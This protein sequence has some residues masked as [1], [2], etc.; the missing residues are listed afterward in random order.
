MSSRKRSITIGGH[1]TSYTLEDAFFAEL[2]RLA[3]GAGLTVTALVA[4]I[5]SAR[6]PGTNLSSAIRLRILAELTRRM[7]RENK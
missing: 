6:A 2:E 7:S 3:A 4:E 1:R 5:D